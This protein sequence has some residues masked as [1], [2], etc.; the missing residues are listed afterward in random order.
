[1]NALQLKNDV[2]RLILDIDDIE[3]LKYIKAFITSDIVESKEMVSGIFYNI[4]I[5]DRFLD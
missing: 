5:V 4:A 3:Q 2:F 1:M